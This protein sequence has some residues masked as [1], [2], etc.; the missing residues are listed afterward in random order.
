MISSDTRRV[1]LPARNIKFSHRVFYM[2]K[3]DTHT[4]Y[5]PMGRV[6]NAM[7]NSRLMT[8]KNVI[9]KYG[10]HGAMTGRGFMAER[11]TIASATDQ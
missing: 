9:L 10:W 8:S 11:N 2:F 7:L 6:G 1:Q 3:V 4:G 5:S